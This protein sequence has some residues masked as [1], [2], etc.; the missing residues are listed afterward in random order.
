[1]EHSQYTVGIICAL[2]LEAAAAAAVLDEEFAALGQDD[3]D[4]NSYKLGRIHHHNVAIA[5]LPSGVYGSTSAASV[6]KDMLR[7]F[8]SLRFG[9]MVGIGGALP[10]PVDEELDIRLGDV[11]IGKPSGQFGGVV[12]FDRGKQTQSSGFERT[13]VLAAPP[14]LLLTALSQLEG[15][16]E[17]GETAITTHL[18]EMFRK[19]PAMARKFGYPGTES[20]NL[21]EAGYAHPP[22]AETCAG[23][24]VSRRVQRIERESTNP[25][26]FC[27]TIASSNSVVKDA[28]TRERLREELGAICF[29]ME[30]AGLADFPCLV[31]RGISDYSDSHKNS[32]WQRYA[33]AT[34]AACAK[35]L[36]GYIGAASVEKQKPVIQVGGLFP[37]DIQPKT[38]FPRLMLH[39][40]PYFTNLPLNSS[41]QRR[42][43]GRKLMRV[44]RKKKNDIKTR[45]RKN[46]TNFSTS[47]RIQL[48]KHQSR[49]YSKHLS[50]GAYE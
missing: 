6:A 36:L 49:P 41:L 20:D 48:I 31:I 11:V 38:A 46:A 7:T 3:L 50:L 21:Y 42:S 22:M 4:H 37:F 12:Q 9:L 15:D 2:P 10:V 40:T 19:R 44:R 13:G 23:C 14:F 28:I 18:S 43:S 47:F 33:A 8:K 29:E 34:A 35:S 16:N 27:G 30:A 24:D 32:K 45:D 26:V 5:S 39:Q 1:M 17:L 25:M